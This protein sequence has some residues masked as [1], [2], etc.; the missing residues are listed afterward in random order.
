MTR[1]SPLSDL[2]FFHHLFDESFKING[3]MSETFWYLENLSEIREQLFA[4][5]MGWVD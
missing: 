4:E 3:N 1:K 2:V 5:F